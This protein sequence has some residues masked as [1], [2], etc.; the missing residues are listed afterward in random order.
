MNPESVL[1]GKAVNSY[2]NQ[3]NLS[4]SLTHK[5][6][7][8]HTQN[9]KRSILTTPTISPSLLLPPICL[10]L[11]S[12]IFNSSPLF[13]FLHFFSVSHSVF[14]NQPIVSLISYIHTY[15]MN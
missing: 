9:N 6:I 3:H 12:F 1:R 10:K 13:P 11:S 15:G 7:F 2:L 8:L 4:L 14:N 5:H